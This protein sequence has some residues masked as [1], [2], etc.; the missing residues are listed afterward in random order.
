VIGG[1]PA[2]IRV[3]FTEPIPLASCNLIISNSLGQP[4][5]ELNSEIPG[6]DDVHDDAQGPLIDC[7]IASLALLPG[8]YRIDVSLRGRQRFQD[9]LRGAA[10]FD[11]EPGT[12]GGRPMA[13]EGAEGDL[14]LEHVWRL[15]S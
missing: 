13:L 14:M 1:R 4:V 9:G 12:V 10:Y 7:E 8:R 2:Q 5:T 15:P 11:V 3:E 6:P